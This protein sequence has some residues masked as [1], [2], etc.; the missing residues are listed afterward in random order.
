MRLTV[1]MMAERPLQP[2]WHRKSTV[3]GDDGLTPAEHTRFSPVTLDGALCIP[4]ASAKE[5]IVASVIGR[6]MNRDGSF[7]AQPLRNQVCVIVRSMHRDRVKALLHLSQR[8]WERKVTSWVEAGMA[9]RCSTQPLVV[10]LFLRPESTC[11]ACHQPTQRDGPV[12]HGVTQDATPAVAQPCL[13]RGLHRGVD[14]GV[15]ASRGQ[16][17]E[18][19]P[20]VQR[21]DQGDRMVHVERG[22]KNDPPSE[23]VEAAK[24]EMVSRPDYLEWLRTKP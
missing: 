15:A 22:E 20:A 23:E 13:E 2:K 9:H 7:A 16:G 21:G 3:R 24:R 4:E 5:F 6:G 12:R 17:A 14:E 1:L 19:G 8:T 18:P 11:P 10:A